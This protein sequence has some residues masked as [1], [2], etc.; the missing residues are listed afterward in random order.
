MTETD[1]FSGLTPASKAKA[2]E[3]DKERF[4]VVD[5]YTEGAAIVSL[6]DRCKAEPCGCRYQDHAWES[7]SDLRVTESTCEPGRCYCRCFQ[8]PEGTKRQADLVYEE[9]AT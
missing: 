7:G 2:K 3:E 6:T 8:P 9:N 4:Y 5:G 1:L